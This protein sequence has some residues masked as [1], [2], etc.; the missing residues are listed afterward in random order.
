[1]HMSTS[2]AAISKAI[3]ASQKEMGGAVKDSNNP[4]FKS[5]YSDLESVIAACKTALNNHGI[6]V[7]QPHSCID[8]A[9]YIETLL[10]HESGEWMMS[11]TR[12]VVAKMNDPQAFGSAISYSR[13]YGLQSLL[14]IPAVDDD[15]EKA[16]VRQDVG[17]APAKMATPSTGFKP[18]APSATGLF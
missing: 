16:M 12:I 17:K 9:D 7:L 18:V 15:G 2:I 14:S 11:H 6:T 3:L 8:G 1:M 10:L 5:K 4:F 13:R